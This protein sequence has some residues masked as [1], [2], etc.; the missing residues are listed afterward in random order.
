[1]G[2]KKELLQRAK[3]YCVLDTQVAG[4]D[5]L[6]DIL[7]AA[8]NAGV[9]IFQ[10]RD[11]CGRFHD[12]CNF[13]RKSLNALCDNK[14][15]IV[16]DRIDV[17][18]DVQADGIH[19]GQED[20]PVKEVRRRIGDDMIL[21]ASCQTL[22]QAFR[23]EKEGADYIGFGSVFKTQ[24]KPDRIPM[25][26][27]L[28]S[29]LMMKIKIPVFPIG[30]ISLDNIDLVKECGAERVAVTRAVCL[31]DDVILAVQGLR[32]ALGRENQ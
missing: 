13:A 26:R 5:R 19:V 28:L 22:D 3:I 29:A 24:T 14:I 4:Y 6:F 23:A 1:M 15:F 31:A 30:G 25:D 21:G 17:A 20:M 10:I 18:L 8:S 12:I 9:D 16:N 7:Q 32:A 11:K 27:R 2:S